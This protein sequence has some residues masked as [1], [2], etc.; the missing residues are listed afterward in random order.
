ML[1]IKDMLHFTY[2]VDTIPTAP[3]NVKATL[4]SEGYINVW[5]D[6]PEK[7]PESVA[8]YVVSYR[9]PSIKEDFDEVDRGFLSHTITGVLSNRQYSIYVKAKNQYGISHASNMVYLQTHGR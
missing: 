1:F 8:E 7:N 5:W 4:S 6:P 9:V 2:F 3:R